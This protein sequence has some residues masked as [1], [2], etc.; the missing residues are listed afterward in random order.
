MEEVQN[1]VASSSEGADHNQLNTPRLT[2]TKK[3]EC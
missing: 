1:F 2:H 3:Q